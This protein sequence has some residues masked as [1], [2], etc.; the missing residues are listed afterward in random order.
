MAVLFRHGDPRFPFLWESAP[1][2]PARWHAVRDAPVSYYAD[3]PDGAWA[4][5]L[6]HE[7]ITDE[8]DLAGIARRMWAV[9]V[10]D[11]VLDTAATPVLD[12]VQL[13]G[14]LTSYPA[15]Q[16]EARRLRRAGAQAMLAPSAALL[17]GGAR[18]QHVDGGLREGG[19]RD[20][21]VLVLF[22]GRWPHL[23]G[24]A[25]TVLGAPTVR[26]L[27]LVRHL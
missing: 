26:M 14:P 10:P 25:A 22:G 4:E 8:A 17:P 27:A 5:L 15:C 11:E 13:L 12:D 2:P 24:W 7:A 19:Q 6:R 3:T 20:G 1:Q 16:D 21:V 9:D 18:G 23:R